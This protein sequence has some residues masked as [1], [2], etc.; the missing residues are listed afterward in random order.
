MPPDSDN[1]VESIYQTV[2]MMYLSLY[3]VLNLADLLTNKKEV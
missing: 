3:Q 1:N 2:A